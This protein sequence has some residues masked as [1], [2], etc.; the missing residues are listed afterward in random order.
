M[1][2]KL[3]EPR[4]PALIP[5]VNS[6]GSRQPKKISINT[7]NPK[8]HWLFPKLDEP[9]K[10]SNRSKTIPNF[11]WQTVGFGA[12]NKNPAFSGYFLKAP[13]WGPD[14]TRLNH[15]RTDCS[16]GPPR[17]QSRELP[18]GSKLYHFLWRTPRHL[19]K[20]CQ[21]VNT[22]EIQ[23]VTGDSTSI[24]CFFRDVF[25]TLIWYITLDQWGMVIHPIVETTTTH[26]NGYINPY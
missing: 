16:A 11:R 7:R 17:S 12:G 2:I 3:I 1:E 10:A 14:L 26:H 23:V 15:S 20:C 21:G 9:Q 5:P 18:R 13:S 25:L 24:F 19:F 6:Q 4:D 22:L 8:I